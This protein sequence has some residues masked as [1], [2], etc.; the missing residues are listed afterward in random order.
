M[1]IKLVDELKQFFMTGKKPTQQQ[2]WD[3]LDSFRHKN[4]KIYFSDLAP[5]LQA[6]FNSFAPT[7]ALPP[8]TLQWA[9]PAGTMLR[10]YL[11]KDSGAGQDVTALRI[12]TTLGGNE[13]YEASETFNTTNPDAGII[14]NSKVLAVATTVYFSITASNLTTISIN[15]YKQ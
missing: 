7:I 3:W 9:A 13:I 10:G 1:A 12:G 5:E 14:D 6:M 4:E 15:I 8:G 2:F 11:I